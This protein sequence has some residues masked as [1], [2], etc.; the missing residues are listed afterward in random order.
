M[1]WFYLIFA[2]LLEVIWPIGLKIA[3]QKTHRLF[4]FTLAALALILSGS[5]LFIA[6][7]SIPLGTAYAVW[8]GIGAV[9][10]FLVG[11]IFYHDHLNFIRIAAALCIVSGIIFMKMAD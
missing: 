1:A 10:A 4:G 8:T 5:F 6:Q 2:G 7:K 9:G 11:V 3:Q